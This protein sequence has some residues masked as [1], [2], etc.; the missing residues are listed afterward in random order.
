MT[1][2]PL[3]APPSRLW[4]V[5]QATGVVLTLLLITTWLIRAIPRIRSAPT[6]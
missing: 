6:D 4:S 1:S 5:A 3:S 2:I